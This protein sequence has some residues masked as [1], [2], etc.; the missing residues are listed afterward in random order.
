MRR[1]ETTAIYPGRYEWLEMMTQMR[2]PRSSEELILHHV[3]LGDLLQWKWFSKT[4]VCSATVIE[5][6]HLPHSLSEII[7]EFISSDYFS[8]S[9]CDLKV[10]S[11]LLTNYIHSLLFDFLGD[12]GKLCPF[13]SNCMTVLYLQTE[14]CEQSGRQT[15][16]FPGI[17]GTGFCSLIY[18]FLSTGSDTQDLLQ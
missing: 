4:W 12:L 18:N 13:L 1:M 6:Y 15:A 10:S 14:M 2:G 5:M 8:P 17:L 16:K 3:V 7:H 9:Q 11:W